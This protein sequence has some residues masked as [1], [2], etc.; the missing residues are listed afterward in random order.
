MRLTSP[1]AKTIVP[2]AIVLPH[3]FMIVSS[4]GQR[5]REAARAHPEVEPDSVLTSRD[6][7][8]RQF[9]AFVI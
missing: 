4:L 9:R 5:T 2:G 8:Q 3:F 6:V 7:A 1:A